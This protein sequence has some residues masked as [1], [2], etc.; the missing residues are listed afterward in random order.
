[1]LAT[2]ASALLAAFTPVV[3][4]DSA[5][6]FPLTSAAAHAPAFR[7]PTDTRPAVYGHAGPARAGGTWL[8]Y[9]LFSAYQDQDRGI[10]RTGR[11]AADW[12]TVQYRVDARGRLLE[13]VYA[14][15]SGAERCGAATV[16]R[17][18]GHPIVYAAHGS[19]AS[20]FHAGTRDRMW[21]DPN[22]EADGRG[23]AVHPRVVPITRDSPRWMTYA[24]PWGPS[25]ASPLIP[26]EQDSPRGPAFQPARWDPERLA[27][28]AHACHAACDHV[29]ECDTRE[30]A[31]GAGAVAVPLALL[32][33]LRLRRRPRGDA[34]G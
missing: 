15:H 24:G 26:P 9:W 6:R 31:L 10:V 11:H 18:S 30:N 21:P 12:E 14:Q 22:D 29:N 34:T 33:L 2:A 28:A 27:A 4:H 23:R 1:V 20:Y 7:D 5:E 32:L 16:E 25:R 17:A 3:V 19:H 13:A 8:Q